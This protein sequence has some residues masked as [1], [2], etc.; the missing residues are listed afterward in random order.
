MQKDLKDFRLLYSIPIVVE[1]P[2]KQG[3]LK[4]H[5]DFVSHLVKKAVG[6]NI[7]KKKESGS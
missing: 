4:D 6:I 7:D 3:R 1:I 5:T 2:D